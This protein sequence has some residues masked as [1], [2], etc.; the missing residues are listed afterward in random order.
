MTDLYY[1][2]LTRNYGDGSGSKY[3]SP[4]KTASD[5]LSEIAGLKVEIDKAKKKLE[6]RSS[7]I[8]GFN[9][10]QDYEIEE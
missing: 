6:Q 7:L 2:S 10:K 5:Y 1:H 4:A 3:Q 9:S 8:Q